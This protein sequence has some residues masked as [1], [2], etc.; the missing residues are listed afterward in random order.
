MN[1]IINFL[2][3]LILW[4]VFYF[5]INNS[6]TMSERFEGSKKC[7]FQPWGLTE[8]ACIS[9][10]QVSGKTL[11][12]RDEINGTE[13][14]EHKCSDICQ[15]CNTPACKW[16]E[17]T[18]ELSFNENDANIICIPGN[19]VIDVKIY[20]NPYMYDTQ[21]DSSDKFFVIH[22][23][24]SRFPHEGI[25]IIKIPIETTEPKFYEY[26]INNKIENDFEYSVMYYYSNSSEPVDYKNLNT[27]SKTSQIIKVTPSKLNI[28][29]KP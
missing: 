14:T 22:Y 2:S 18:T 24:K 29:T 15:T 25:H 23:Y 4:S 3:L 16:L 11:G 6:D 8:N 9:R 5:Y 27:L 20:Y 12:I 26:S 13:C 7:K 1:Y 10:C 21:T 19:N 28:I 17:E